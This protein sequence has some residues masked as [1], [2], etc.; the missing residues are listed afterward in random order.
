MK[1]IDFLPSDY[2]SHGRLRLPVLFLGILLLQAR[3][4]VLFVM[5]GASRQQGD[6][7]L[8]LFYPDHNN[9]WLGLLPGIPAVIAFLLSGRRHQFPRVWQGIRWL[10]I[11]AQLALLLWQ[12]LLWWQGDAL[13]GIGLTLVIL[14][15]F[16]L[17]WL[18][19]SHRLR[20][21]FAANGTF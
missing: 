5:A 13:S 18:L 8:N 9:F 15:G 1:S 11:I 21:C 10:L 16:A 6:T 3:T 7:L 14:D 19:S 17:W 2:D 4:W 12:P 20:A